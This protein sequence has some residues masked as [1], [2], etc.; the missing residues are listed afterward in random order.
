MPNITLRRVRRRRQPR[1]VLPRPRSLSV[2]RRYASLCVA[3]GIPAFD[4]SRFMGHTK[5]TTTLGIYAHLFEDD[6]AD[7][8]AALG[9]MG[10]LAPSGNVIRLR[11]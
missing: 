3:A 1:R 6:H 2:V 4:I 8:M 5:P 9:A 11:G 7:V 10:S